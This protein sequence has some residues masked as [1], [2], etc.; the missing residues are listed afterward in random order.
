MHM[1]QVPEP[2][3][4]RVLLLLTIGMILG[5]AF[6][7]SLPSEI[8]DISHIFLVFFGILLGVLL[9]LLTLAYLGKCF[10]KNFGSLLLIWM[11]LLA[12]CLGFFRVYAFHRLQHRTLRNSVNQPR[13]YIGVLTDTPSLSSSQ[14]TLR[15][16]VKLLYLSHNGLRQDCPGKILLYAPPE[17]SQ[18]LKIDDVI[19]FSATLQ[20]PAGPSYLGGFS[21]RDYLYRQ[22]CLYLAQT[23]T[24]FRINLPYEPGFLD[25]ITAL[26][27]RIRNSMIT[28]VDQSFDNTSEES[29]LLKGILLGIQED[30]STEQYNAFVDSGLI[31]ITSVSGMHVMFLSSFLLAFL[32]KLRIPKMVIYFLLLPVLFVFSSVAA[33]TPSVCRSTI[34]MMFFFLAQ[35][36]QREPD[37]LTS[38]SAAA[39]LL[40]LIN[41]YALTSYSFLLSFSSTAGIIL[42]SGFIGHFLQKPFRPKEEIDQEEPGKWSRFFRRRILNPVL[43]SISVTAGCLLGM[44]YFSMRFF[45]RINWGSFLANLCLLPFASASF[46]LGILN[47]PLFHL[48]PSLSRLLAQGPLTLI[49]W[50]INRIAEIFSHPLFRITTPTPPASF[51]PVYLVFCLAIYYNL[52]PKEKNT[53]NE[54]IS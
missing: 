19:S 5:I 16:P 39:L 43:L 51:L 3:G 8:N 49:L 4:H 32:R 37:P 15:L 29:A 24:I 7:I 46:L 42:F 53:E 40:L 31:H 27:V 21:M 26:G 18:S 47:W 6:A 34:M 52:I 33:F 2:K 13:Q 28:S 35:L 48:C 23:K 45:Q 36:L 41:P 54:N 11:M 38:L 9:F 25:T 30:F 1:N 17:L 10:W 14:K 20:E 50:C 44:G 12:F 22:N